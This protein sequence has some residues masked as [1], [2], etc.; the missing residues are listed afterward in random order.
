[1]VLYLGL[2]RAVI[3]HINTPVETY[4]LSLTSVNCQE[5]HIAEVHNG[6]FWNI[7]TPDAAIPQIN[8]FQ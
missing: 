5:N 7:L 8:S 4:P 6:L 3:P 1:M 2:Y